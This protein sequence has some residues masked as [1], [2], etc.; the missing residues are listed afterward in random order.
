MGGKDRKAIFH[1]W[2]VG[3]GCFLAA[4]AALEDLCSELS[5]PVAWHKQMQCADAGF[6]GA[7]VVSV[8]VAAAFWAAFVGFG[9]EILCQFFFHN[10]LQQCLKES[11]HRV[12]S[13]L[14]SLLP[15]VKEFG[16]MF[17]HGVSS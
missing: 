15:E 3:G 11:T 5:V 8:A 7:G 4:A 2:R 6:E 10:S 12:V 14:G 13:F 1:P 17:L 16:R 9:V